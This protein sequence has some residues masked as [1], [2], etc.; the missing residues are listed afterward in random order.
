MD[1]ETP[2]GALRGPPAGGP[3]WGFSGEQGQLA[4]LAKHVEEQQVCPGRELAQRPQR[5]LSPAPSPGLLGPW[6]NPSRSLASEPPCMLFP[7][8]PPSPGTRGPSPWPAPPPGS[9][10]PHPHRLPPCG[11]GPGTSHHCSLVSCCPDPASPRPAQPGSSAATILPPT[12]LRPQG[13]Q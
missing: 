1:A 13:I 9:S 6:G 5:S 2:R 8:P 4:H 3:P 7:L 10:L 12:P 11:R